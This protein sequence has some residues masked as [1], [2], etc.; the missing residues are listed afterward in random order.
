MS[1]FKIASRFLSFLW[2]ADTIYD[3]HS[4]FVYQLAQATLEDNRHFYAFTLVESVR[5]M[6][7]QNH[8]R[9]AVKDFGAGSKVHNG[10]QRKVSDIA[11]SAVSPPNKTQLLFRIIN[12]FK[13]EKMLEI[14]TSLGISTLYQKAAARNAQLITLEGSPQIAMEAQKAFRA[15]EVPLDIDLRLGQFEHTLEQALQDLERLD[16]V[17]IDGNH[18]KKPTLAYFE[19]CLKYAH[20]D[21]V[22]VFDDIYWSPE[23]QDAWESIKAHPKVELSVDFFHMGVVFFRTEQQT[24]QH[25]KVIKSKWKPWSFGFFGKK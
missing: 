4:P 6:H 21:S 22:F 24:K 14:G 11:K 23:M 13:P 12:H 18:R 20:A 25:F 7:L 17:F 16:Y 1:H 5:Q 3:I 9:I 19:S 8:T 10:N 2:K 15:Y